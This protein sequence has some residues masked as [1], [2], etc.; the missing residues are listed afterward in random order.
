MKTLAE[1]LKALRKAAGFTQ[2]ELAKRVGVTRGAL[3]N[4]EVGGEISAA[5]MRRISEEFDGTL[6]WL[7]TGVGKPPAIVG[8]RTL[9][10]VPKDE[11]STDVSQLG[12]APNANIGGKNV[13]GWQEVPVYGQAVAGEDGEFLMNGNIMFTALAPPSVVAISNAYGVRVSGL[14]M[15]PRYYDG[16]VVFVDPSR[17]PRAG[18]FVV[19]Q[20]KTDEHGE[21]WGFVKRY[22]RRNTKELVL[23]QFNPEKVLTFRNDQVA[24]CHVIVMGGMG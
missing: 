13:G 1:R 21:L 3:A 15:E 24:S 8:N 9:A 12:N 17:I 2:E 22:V 18:D 4:W 11:D 7:A 5:N 23:S 6:D 10:E 16:E 20:V 19:V 14:S